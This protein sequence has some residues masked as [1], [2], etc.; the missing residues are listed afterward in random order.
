[1]TITYGIL[2][3]AYVSASRTK[4]INHLIR[5][6]SPERDL[7]NIE[8]LWFLCDIN[9]LIVAQEGEKIVGMVMLVRVSTLTCRYCLVEDLVVHDQYP[10]RDINK[11]LVKETIRWANR[12]YLKYLDFKIP[13]EKEV[14]ETLNDQYSLLQ[15][16]DVGVW[17]LP[18]R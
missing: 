11:C 17:R 14:M 5:Q 10:G 18:L 2:Q 8:D 4:E 3:P 13:Q 1:M 15:V 6:I 7:I 16:P 9:T 12:F